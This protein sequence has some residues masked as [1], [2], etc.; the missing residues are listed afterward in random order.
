MVEIGSFFRA[1]RKPAEVAG[2]GALAAS[3]AACGGGEAPKTP[4]T[5]P[6][7]PSPIV[8]PGEMPSMTPSPS[9][10]VTPSPTATSTP[11]AIESSTPSPEAKPIKTIIAEIVNK[12]SKEGWKKVTVQQVTDSINAAYDADQTAASFI[13][14]IT[15]KPHREIVTNG[16]TNCSTD[17]DNRHKVQLCGMLEG[18]LYYGAFTAD[19]NQVWVDGP[20]TDV[21]YYAHETLNAQDFNGFVGNAESQ[22]NPFNP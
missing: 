21:V 16:W 10:E 9:F 14:P 8:T 3:I 7:T 19:N 2:A 11:T 17:K 13:N 1:L 6:A 15:G 18:Y 20:I 4:N 22:S 12:A 5:T